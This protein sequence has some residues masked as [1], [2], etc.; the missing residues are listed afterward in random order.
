MLSVNDGG[1]DSCKSQGRHTR[2][3]VERPS[4]RLLYPHP[5]RCIPYFLK[6]SPGILKPFYSFYLFLILAKVPTCYVSFPPFPKN[7]WDY[8]T[9]YS[10]MNH[11]AKRK[12]EK[13]WRTKLYAR[14]KHETIK[15]RLGLRIQKRKQRAQPHQ[16]ANIRLKFWKHGVGEVESPAGCA[17][18]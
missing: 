10:S 1:D 15:G 11:T 9:A 2:K 7:K 5:E 18:D 6:N 13:T 3:D 4:H 12:L 16:D 8:R 14:K 17:K